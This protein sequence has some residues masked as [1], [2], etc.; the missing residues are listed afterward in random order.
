MS[1]GR[2]YYCE[3][4]F[5]NITGNGNRGWPEMPVYYHCIGGV[6]KVSAPDFR[7]ITIYAWQD[8]MDNCGVQLI[9]TTNPKTANII[10]RGN[11]IDGP[12]K[13]LGRAYLPI[14]LRSNSDA[15]GENALGVEFDFENLSSEEIAPP[16]KLSAPGIWRHE[17]GHA[18]AALEH[19]ADNTGALMRSFYDP[20]VSK[21]QLHDIKRLQAI[22]P[23]RKDS[24]PSNPTGKWT[25]SG[26]GY[27][28]T[29]AK[30]PVIKFNGKLQSVKDSPFSG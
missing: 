30:Q 11:Q 21:L 27:E 13:T 28:L 26:E 25:I 15:V 8:F 17:G 29:T 14:G 18:I 3:M 12:G 20:Q 5:L 9:Y 10:L 19:A 1:D 7:D 23:L 6:G 2:L 24:P 4:K 22:Y 16:G